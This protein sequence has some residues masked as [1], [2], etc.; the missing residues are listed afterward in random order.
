MTRKYK[1]YTDQDII[2]KAKVSKSLAELLRLLDLKY[3]GGN[4]ANMQR[5]LQRLNIDTSH[6][7]GKGW[8]KDKQLKDWSDYSRG[9]HLKP[10]LIKARGH[11]CESCKRKNWLKKPI[12]LELEHIDGDRTNN[13]DSNLKLLCPNCHSLTSTW[14]RPKG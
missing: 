11:K 10:H 5:N 13:K 8:S 6:W 4:Y 3:A 12:T 7:T 1:N 9:I 14:R 2:D